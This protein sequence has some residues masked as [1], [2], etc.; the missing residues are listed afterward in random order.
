M[1][2]IRR[3]YAVPR[4]TLV[5]LAAEFGVSTSTVWAV[6]RGRVW[7]H[8]GRPEGPDGRSPR[9]GL[10]EAPGDCAEGSADA[11]GDP[12]Y[13]T[14]LPPCNTPNPQENQD[15]DVMD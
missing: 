2:E 10:G 7:K 8:V 11:V 5:G 9:R 13:K 3:R 1:E 15:V 4:P 6:V 14:I 12:L